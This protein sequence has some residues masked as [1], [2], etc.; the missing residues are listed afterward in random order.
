MAK[1]TYLTEETFK[2]AFESRGIPS[3]KPCVALH[4]LI[5]EDYKKTF[6]LTDAQME[7]MFIKA[8]YVEWGAIMTQGGNNF[9]YRSSQDSL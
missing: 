3:S 1:E 7:K 9:G 6:N 2:R 4:P 5:W 8:A